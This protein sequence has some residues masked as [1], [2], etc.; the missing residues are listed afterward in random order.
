MIRASDPEGTLAAGARDLGV[1]LDD[2]RRR[3]LL[4]YL[5]L[6]AHWNRSFNL[7][8]VRDPA[9][10]VPRH[11]LDSLSLVPLLTGRR[12]LDVGSGAGL[13]GLVLAVAVTSLEVTLLDAS[14]KRTRFLLHACHSLGIGNVTVVR[15][16]LESYR[17]A[18]AFDV[19]T[20][21]ASLPLEV[22]L[23]AAPPLLAPGGRLL[24]MQGRAP[25]PAPRPPA[26]FRLRIRALQVP[27]L[28]ARRHVVEMAADA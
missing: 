5:A 14:G 10:M 18:R 3:L 12:L 20:S 23:E 26:G 19:V 7:T 21:R 25:E 15:E 1:A 24:A 28:E 9:R 27:S 4:E 22:L 8:A 13:P 2:D 6:L 16:R 17:P 11:L